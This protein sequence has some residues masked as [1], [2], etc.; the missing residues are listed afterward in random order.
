MS[1]LVPIGLRRHVRAS[2]SVGAAPAG[3]AQIFKGWNV[4]DVWQSQDPIQGIGG[5]ILNAGL[6]LDRQ[7]KIWIEDNIKD[8]APGV[9]VAD[10]ANPMA[11]KGDQ[12]QIVPA[13]GGLAVL[14]TRADVP[15]L[16]GAL[17]LGEMGSQGLK[18]TV[19]FFNRGIEAAIAWPHDENYLLD[20]VYQPDP[21]NAITSGP[22]PSSLA[23]AAGEA[24][25]TAGSVLKVVAIGAGVA[26]G[27]V[28]IAALVNASRKAEPA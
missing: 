17:Q 24:L 2:D 26:L 15:G 27:V 12:I 1:A 8:N 5:S 19:R 18:R 28:L 10:P 11:L 16:A 13:A 9:A 6:S 25:D 23:G 7:L 20:T 22:A 3:F 14:Q 4:W 21:A